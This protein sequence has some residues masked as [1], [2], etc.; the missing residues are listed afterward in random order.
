[1]KNEVPTHKMYRSM[2]IYIYRERENYEWQGPAAVEAVTVG[3]L[4]V[5]YKERLVMKNKKC[6]LHQTWPSLKTQ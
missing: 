6:H 3:Q 1:M 2:K 5:S 4:D